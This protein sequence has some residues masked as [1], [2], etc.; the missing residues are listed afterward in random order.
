MEKTGTIKFEH[1]SFGKKTEEYVICGLPENVHNP[2]VLYH[3]G[4]RRCN[5]HIG[6]GDDD[7]RGR[8][9]IRR[10]G[11]RYRNRG[12]NG[13]HDKHLAGGGIHQ[14]SMHDFGILYRRCH[15]RI[16]CRLVL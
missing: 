1:I 14:R 11:E 3:G 15:R 4:D 8:I 2:A 12:G 7:H 10:S 9:Y 6:T 5:S 16:Y 13:T